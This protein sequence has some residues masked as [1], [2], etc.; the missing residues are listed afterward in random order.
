VSHL[1]NATTVDVRG[2]AIRRVARIYPAYWAVLVFFTFAVPRLTIVGMKGFFLNTTLTQ[3]Y[4][5]TKNAFFVGL[6]P[7]WSLVVEMTFYAFLPF[8]AAAIAALARRRDALT[9]ELVG[10]GVLFVLGVAAI[11]A[12][13]AGYA[14][15]WF[16]M[17]PIHLAAFAL[18]IVL[19][20][21]SSAHFGP[22]TERRLAWA[23]RVTWLWWTL[24]MVAFLSIPLCFRVVPFRDLS[25]VQNAGLNL[26]QTL[27]GFF[28]V[29]PAVL[30]PQH[31][32]AIRRLLTSRVLVFVGTISYGL[33]LWHWFVLRTVQADWYGWRLR[34]GNYVKLLAL[35]LPV[36][37]VA[38]TASW[39][40]LERPILDRARALAHLVVARRSA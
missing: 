28:V 4:V 14:P 23:G 18:G 27:I 13:S 30:G 12:M 15:A 19:A 35:A 38:A 7:A 33:Y 8:Y 17:L 36:A 24:A 10:V 5:E 1:T 6:P 31:E 40:L 9:V 39:Y 21:V 37:L 20:V 2:Y 34:E 16:N 29:I 22:T 25:I 3:G 11:V 26:L 32:G